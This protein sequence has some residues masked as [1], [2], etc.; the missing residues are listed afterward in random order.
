[1]KKVFQKVWEVY[2]EKLFNLEIAYSEVKYKN[3]LEMQRS[4]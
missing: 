4:Q 1:M 3:G 2:R